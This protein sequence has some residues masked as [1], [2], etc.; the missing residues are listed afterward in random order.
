MNITEELVSAIKTESEVGD[1]K[2]LLVIGASREQVHLDWWEEV[3][4]SYPDMNPNGI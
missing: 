1:T 3:L 4:D 2:F